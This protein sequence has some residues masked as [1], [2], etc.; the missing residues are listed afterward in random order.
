MAGG[1]PSTWPFGGDVISIANGVGGYLVPTVV[2]AG[3][4]DPHTLHAYQLSTAMINCALQSSD[5]NVFTGCNN[6]FLAAGTVLGQWNMDGGVPELVDVA[7]C[8]ATCWG[9]SSCVAWDM[10]KVTRTSG[11]VVPLCTLYSSAV[12]QCGADTNQWAGVKAPLPGGAGV[13]QQWTLP[14]SWVGRNVTYALVTP[15]GVLPG[16][17]TVLVSGRNLTVVLPPGRPVRLSVAHNQ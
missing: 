17:P 1:P 14:L 8:N 4:L 5:P 10:I 6:T 2:A 9:N 12:T 15:D 3:A 16:Q 11:K 7:F 13:T